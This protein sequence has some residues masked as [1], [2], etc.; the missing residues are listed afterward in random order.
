MI[1]FIL[2]FHAGVF[3]LRDFPAHLDEEQSVQM[4]MVICARAGKQILFLE[5]S[6]HTVD[7]LI[8]LGSSALF[9]SVLFSARIG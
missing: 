1:G 4:A 2:N 6:S 7:I 5:H 8:R 9:G 3:V